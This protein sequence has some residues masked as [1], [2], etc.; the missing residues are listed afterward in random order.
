MNQIQRSATGVA[1][2]SSDNGDCR[3]IVPLELL[4]ARTTQDMIFP[5]T[6]AQKFVTETDGEYFDFRKVPLFSKGWNR[7]L[8]I[9]EAWTPQAAAYVLMSRTENVFYFG[10]T[11]NAYLRL[12]GHRTLLRKQKHK[13]KRLSEIVR[14]NGESDLYAIVFYCASEEK[15]RWLEQQLIVGFEKDPRRLNW[16]TDQSAPTRGLCLNHGDKLRESWRKPGVRERRSQILRETFANKPESVVRATEAR[17]R[18][19]QED[20]TIRQRIAESSKQWWSNEENRKKRSEEASKFFRENPDVVQRQIQARSESVT[21]VTI[22]GVDYP[23]CVAAGLALNLN[24]K[25]VSH[26]CRYAG[27]RWAAWLYR[28]KP[29]KT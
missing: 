10:S 3:E 9:S 27:P 12:S 15:A 29:S 8:G 17:K 5:T 11:N 21:P 19:F 28:D 26:R 1:Y 20:P 7:G 22:V 16:G 24:T 14:T 13:Q 4:L 25:V 6:S 18:R 23:S 2:L